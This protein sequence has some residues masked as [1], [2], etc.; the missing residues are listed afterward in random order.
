MATPK[1]L[2]P[3][4][5]AAL[6]AV[7][8]MFAS[9]STVGKVALR[10]LAP[11]ALIALRVAGAAGIF[12]LIG[13]LR[14]WERVRARDLPELFA[15]AL[16]GVIANQLFFIEGLERSTATN[17]I[18]IGTIIPVF[19]VGVALALGSEK[20]TPKK[21][22]GLLVAL[23]GALY[24]V[25]AGRLEAGG[26]QLVGNLLFV[27]NSLSFAI[28]LVI[29]RRLL[30]RYRSI[31]VVAW[32]FF[33]GALGTIPWGAAAAVRAVPHLSAAT[34]LA[35]AYIVVSPTVGT[36]FLNTFA[37][38]RAPA[39]MVA[40]YIYIQPL[41]GAVLAAAVLGERPSSSTAVGGVLIALGVWLV[42]REARRLAA[43]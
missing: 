41:F 37:L 28:Y 9:L 38:R 2:S 20:A 12:A 22:L 39:S 5:H 3:S 36:Y 13:A 31:T 33:F 27:L 1:K 17:A 32:T 30:A 15:Y 34:W 23:A 40:I 21:V 29:S 26:A 4:V 6:V 25:G 16:F 42:S 18:I 24:V 19:T 35:L 10:E 7:Q 8:L 14:G 11:T 43:G